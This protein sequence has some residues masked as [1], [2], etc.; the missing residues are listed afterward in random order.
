LQLQTALLR[1]DSVAANADAIAQLGN[2]PLRLSWLERAMTRQLADGDAKAA[3]ATYRD[4]QTLLSGRTDSVNAF[5]LHTL[6]AQAYG[7]LGDRA[8]G[9]AA[10]ARAADSLGKLRSGLPGDLLTSFNAAANV[11]AFEGAGH[12]D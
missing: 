7:K 1:P 5:T 8:A 10:R 3:S 2:L 4:A 12:G 11:R 6:G 9:S